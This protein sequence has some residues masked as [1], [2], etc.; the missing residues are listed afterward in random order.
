M[1]R[2][3]CLA[4]LLAGCVAPPAPTP[5][6]EPSFLPVAGA[7]ASRTAGRMLS[8]APHAARMDD[9]RG[10]PTGLVLVARDPATLRPTALLRVIG[11]RGQVATLALERGTARLGD[12]LVEPAP[13]LLAE[14][15][16]LPA[17]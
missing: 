7:P 13:A 17:P 11:G 10:A 4:A 2:A 6:A 15:R 8:L 9:P 1:R 12:E 5:P 14:A 3:A 16:R